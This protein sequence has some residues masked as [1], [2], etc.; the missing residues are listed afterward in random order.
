MSSTST[1]SLVVAVVL[2]GGSCDVYLGVD[3][4][5]HCQSVH[6]VAGRSVCK[7]QV[8]AVHQ[9]RHY[10]QYTSDNIGNFITIYHF[11]KQS[12]ATFLFCSRQTKTP[13]V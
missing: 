10:T 3:S 11:H 8:V 5:G 4:V 12:S 13:F 7:W 6:S 1:H 9:V 2:C